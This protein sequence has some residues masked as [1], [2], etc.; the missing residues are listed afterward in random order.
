MHPILTLRESLGR[1]RKP[2]KRAEDEPCRVR[3][4]QNPD[5]RR[6]V[7]LDTEKCIT[8]ATLPTTITIDSYYNDYSD[9]EREPVSDDD[10]AKDDNGSELQQ[11]NA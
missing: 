11:Q 2:L 5:A 8:Q 10:D 9:T 4:T 1:G 7:R 3:R 6:M